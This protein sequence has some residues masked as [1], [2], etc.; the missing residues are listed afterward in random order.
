MSVELKVTLVGED[1][2]QQQAF[3]QPATA[4]TAPQAETSP[5]PQPT[6][7]ASS[8]TAN[9]TGKPTPP[10][11]PDWRPP[12]QAF[13]EPESQF[14]DT[15]E[16]LIE[17]LNET[18][19][20]TKSSE[21]SHTSARQ[22]KEKQSWL[23]QTAEKIDKRIDDLGLAHTALGDLVS[24]MSH[25][26][27]EIGT[28]VSKFASSAFGGAA[29]AAGRAA[30]GAAGA[31]AEAAAGTGAAAAGAGAEAGAAGAGVAAGAAGALAASGPLIGVAL[32]AGAAALSLKMFLDAVTKVAHDLADLSPEIAAGQAQ[33][34]S[35]MELM[36]LD[37]A[38]R[39]GAD[40]AGV[41]D[42]QHRLSESMY[43][44]QTKIYELILKAAP[45]IELGV[46]LLNVIVRT[47]DVQ[48]AVM[49]TIAA[50]ITVWNPADDVAAAKEL[51]KSL[52]G[53]ADAW[54]EVFDMGGQ[55]GGVNG[56]D[57]FFAE[58]MMGN[59]PPRNAAPP[60]RGKGP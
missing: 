27:A 24:R 21:S 50:T 38:K 49:N 34:E 45:A 40:V 53:V 11:A 44:V 18:T 31:G 28:R 60:H 1:P 41:Q 55:H 54:K 14:I 13:E 7:P 16:R 23:D 57:P 47:M 32:A 58:L 33:H 46:D 42:A 9:A 29:P 15:I 6:Q 3:N 5:T 12:S 19:A 36:R 52:D 48:I 51:K 56:M 37:R 59:N 4:S 26:V 22:P 35:T 8:Q 43:E 20:A 25:N 10:P 30:A 2:Q 17:A 39:I